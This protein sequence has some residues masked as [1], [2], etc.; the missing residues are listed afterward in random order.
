MNKTNYVRSDIIVEYAKPED[1]AAIVDIQ[2]RTWLATYPNEQAGVTT[3]DIREHLEG[4]D[5]EMV[6][7]RI[8]RW[9]KIIGRSGVGSGTFVARLDYKVV[10]YSSCMISDGQ[11]LVGALYVLPEA[12]GQGLGG[13]LLLEAIGWHRRQAPNDPIF[14][15]V[16]SYNHNAIGFYE[17]YGFVV[18]DKHVV[19]DVGSLP[20]GVVI[21]E[22][23][24]KLS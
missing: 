6:A 14:L 18:T 17:R 24:M 11:R 4:R 19:D 21:P 7:K 13:R 1:A 12:Q 2:K 8:T 3:A 16:A 9:G 15:H 20:S 23:E 10:G 5:G 22:F